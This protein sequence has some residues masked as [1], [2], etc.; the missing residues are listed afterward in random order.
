MFAI[1]QCNCI[2][3]FLISSLG[4]FTI[5]E[6]NIDSRIQICSGFGFHNA[7][8]VRSPISPTLPQ[9]GS[10]LCLTW[11]I[12]WSF[13]ETRNHVLVTSLLMSWSI[14]QIIHYSFFGFKEAFPSWL[15][16]L[17]YD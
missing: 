13:P 1:I 17:R 9:I 14:T 15:L 6:L 4:G 3:I 12:L 8:L 11:G 5:S 7:G 16:W 2:L 10:R